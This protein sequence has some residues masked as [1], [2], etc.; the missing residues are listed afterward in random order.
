MASFN[1]ITICGYL[2][3]DP[4]KRFTQDGTAVCSFSIATTEKYKSQGEM[5]ETTTWFKVTCWR[6]LAERVSEYLHKGSAAY[7]LGRLS[8]EVWQDNEGTT[9]T[10]LAVTAID[11][12]FLGKKDDDQ[13]E[14]RERQSGREEPKSAPVDDDDVPF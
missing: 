14:R 3:K 4:E 10:T 5:K 2:G 12:K 7:V 9:R 6:Q 8:T 11:V 1:L 13:G